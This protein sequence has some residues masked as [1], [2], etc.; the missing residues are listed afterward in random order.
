MTDLY[1]KDNAVYVGGIYSDSERQLHE[2]AFSAAV[3]YIDETTMQ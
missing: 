2:I 1:K 3:A